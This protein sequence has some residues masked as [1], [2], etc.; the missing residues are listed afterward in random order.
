MTKVADSIMIIGVP[1]GYWYGLGCFGSLIGD[2]PKC[3]NSATSLLR[4][5]KSVVG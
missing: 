4:H 1:T 2:L 5:R 3:S